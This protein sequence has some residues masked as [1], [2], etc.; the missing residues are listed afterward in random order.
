MMKKSCGLLLACYMTITS[1]LVG[2][3]T[4]FVNGYGFNNQPIILVPLTGSRWLVVSEG[5]YHIEGFYK[6]TVAATVFNA[7]GKILYEK[8]LN[9]AASEVHRVKCAVGTLDGGFVIGVSNDLCDVI[10]GPGDFICFH[11]NGDVKWH[12]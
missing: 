5:N 11:P 3:S 2:Q 12:I 4:D 1:L 9:L 7:S 6:D 8:R 10:G